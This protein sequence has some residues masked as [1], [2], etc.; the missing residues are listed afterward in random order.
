MNISPYHEYLLVMTDG[1]TIGF[2]DYESAKAY[3][4]LYYYQKVKNDEKVEELDDPT[5][6]SEQLINT[7]CKIIGVDEG[8]VALYKIDDVI[9]KIQEEFV[10]EDEKEEIISKLLDENIQLNVIDLGIDFILH[11]VDSINIIETYGER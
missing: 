3:I 9:E 10:F 1:S 5:D 11:D 7:T 4:N 8:E 2:Q 6:S